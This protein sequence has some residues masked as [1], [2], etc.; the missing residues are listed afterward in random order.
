MAQWLGIIKEIYCIERLA[1]ILR[2]EMEKCTK[3][4]EK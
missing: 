2:L 1:F 3:Y 4:W